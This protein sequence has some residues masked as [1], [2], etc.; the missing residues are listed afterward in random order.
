MRLAE[1]LLCVPEICN[2]NAEHQRLVAKLKGVK[3]YLSFPLLYAE[4][5]FTLFLMLIKGRKVEQ[6]FFGRYWA[7][8]LD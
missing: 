3:P 2:A 6:P 7:K 1:I 5:C 4:V 8:N